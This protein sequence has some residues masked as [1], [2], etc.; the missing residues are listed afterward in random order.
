M[1][2]EGVLDL[3]QVKDLTVAGPVSARSACS[4]QTLQPFQD[5]PGRDGRLL[6]REDQLDP[7]GHHGHVEVTA[8]DG[9]QLQ[10]G[11]GILVEG[12]RVHGPAGCGWP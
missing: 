7:A 11:L 6:R 3:V 12:L 5:H 1:V 10:D 9:S 4:S 8:F 2:A